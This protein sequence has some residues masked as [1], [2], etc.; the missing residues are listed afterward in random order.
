MVW[1]L[2]Q[3]LLSG[4]VFEYNCYR[5]GDATYRNSWDMR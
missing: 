1:G 5:L 2:R 4:M 3:A